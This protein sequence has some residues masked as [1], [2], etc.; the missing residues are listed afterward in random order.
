V[1]ITRAAIVARVPALNAVTDPA[2]WEAAIAD[3]QLQVSSSAWGD[4]YELGVVYLAAHL[5]LAGNPEAA[6]PGPV[7]SETV[8]GV[9][10]SYAVS[11]APFRE[12]LASTTAGREH[13][14]LRR[15]LGLGAALV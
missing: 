10:V 14:R 11:A 8:G 6:A 2:A 9:S 15:M 4:L 1:A 13:I 5:L 3:A 12:Q 7:Q